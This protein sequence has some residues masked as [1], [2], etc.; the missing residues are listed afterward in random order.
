MVVAWATIFG[1]TGVALSLPWLFG[2]LDRLIDGRAD[3]RS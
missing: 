3:D 1:L 2:I